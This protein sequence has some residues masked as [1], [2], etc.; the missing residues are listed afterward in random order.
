MIIPSMVRDVRFYF[1]HN[2]RGDYRPT[3][4]LSHCIEGAFGM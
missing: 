4:E 2:N 1:T 3:S